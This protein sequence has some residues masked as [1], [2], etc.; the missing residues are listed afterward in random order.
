MENI[1]TLLQ[2]PLSAL[3]EPAWISAIVET[4]G[5]GL[6]LDLHNLHANAVNFRSDPLALLAGMPLHRVRTIHIAG[7]KWITSPGGRPVLLD[8]HLHAVDDPVYDLLAEVAACTA[9][10]LTVIL[11]RDG[12]YP[13]MNV[14]LAEL[15]RARA[16]LAAGRA[17]RCQQD[18]PAHAG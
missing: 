13:A 7:G 3:S 18:A 1:A 8:D 2:P 17:R 9:A 10:P 12:A 6:L 15:D 4:A 16:A 14:L 5:C 11:E